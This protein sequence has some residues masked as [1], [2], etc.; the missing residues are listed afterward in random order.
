MGR[1]LSI[2]GLSHK[3]SGGCGKQMI[4]TYKLALGSFLYRT[5]PLLDLTVGRPDN[6]HYAKGLPQGYGE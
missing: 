2:V 5:R 1:L 3:V 4:A 6:R